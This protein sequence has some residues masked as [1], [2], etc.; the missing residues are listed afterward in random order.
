VR[1]LVKLGGTLLEDGAT[2]AAIARQ[3]ATVSRMAE[4]AVVHGGGKQV[5][6]FLHR[7]GVSSEFVDG[8][9]ISDETVIDAVTKVIGGGVNK[10]FVSALLRAGVPALG[11]TGIDGLLTRAVQLDPKLGFV[12]KPVSTNP[13]LL[14][15][16]C[17]GG[18]VPVIACIAADAE[19]TI[20]NVNADEMAISCAVAFDADRLFFLT[21]VPGVKDHDGKVV[22][23]LTAPQA[24]NLIRAGVANGGMQAKLR[25]ALTGLEHGLSEVDIAP[26]RELEVCLRLLQG[27]TLG[28]SI[29]KGV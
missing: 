3:L 27:E 25:A 9:R 15:L 23:T 13:A 26:G 4:L 8:L 28:T 29:V 19:G 16:L 2:R 10:R 22:P 20:F 21:D 7:A 5:T 24:L 17:G 14:D 12:G 1:V 6:D 18:Y 11:L